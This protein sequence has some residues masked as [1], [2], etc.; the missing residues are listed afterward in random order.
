MVR[1]ATVFNI[2]CTCIVIAGIVLG[3]LF[4]WGKLLSGAES[5][6]VR[7]P[8]VDSPVIQTPAFSWPLNLSVGDRISRRENREAPSALPLEVIQPDVRSLRLEQA[9]KQADLLTFEGY[10]LAGRGALF[11]ARAEFRAALIIL[12]QALDAEKRTS[13]H[14][15][16]LAAAW[17]ALKEAEDF[18][19]QGGNGVSPLNLSEIVARH[20]SPVL[21][22]HP[23]HFLTP[24]EA[25]QI[26]LGFAQDLLSR[27]VASE[28]TGSMALRGLGKIYAEWKGA[29]SLSQG[30]SEAQAMVFYQAALNVWPENYMA[31]NDL[32]VLLAR[33]ERWE[34][35]ACVL[36]YAR[37]I[38]PNPIILANLSKVYRQTGRTYQASQILVDLPNASPPGDVTR[39]SFAQNVAWV[40]PETL[41]NDGL[42][43]ERTN[44]ESRSAQVEAK[45]VGGPAAAGAFPTGPRFPALPF[46]KS[47]T[48]M[49]SPPG[50]FPSVP[51][52]QSA[53]LSTGYLRVSQPQTQHGGLPEDMQVQGDSAN[54]V[55]LPNPA[56]PC[57]RCAVDGAIC[58]PTKWGGWNRARMIAWE[59]FA[60]GE[61]VGRAR[62]A[63]VPEYRLRVDDEL[64]IV[65]RIT[66]EE[67]SRPYRLN[68]GDQLKI[69]SATDPSLNR[70]VLIQPDGTITLLLLGQV[71]ATGLT[72]AQ[73]RDSLEQL[74]RRYYRVPAITVTPV[75]VNSKLEDLRATVDRRAGEGGQSQNVRVTPEGTIALPGLGSVKAQ[76]LTLGELQ[77]ELNERYRE[78]VEGIEAMPILV[79]RAPRYVYVLG[80][81]QTPG[82]FELTGPTTVIQAISMA[83]GWKMGANLRQ[84]VVFRRGD[85]WRLMATMLDI[86]AAL[87]GNKATPRDEIWLSD[88]DVVIV[89]KSFIQR[90]D[91]FIEM[92]FTRGIYGVLPLQTTINFSKLSTI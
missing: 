52:S 80:E 25:Y 29:G 26:Y 76:G 68:V 39:D 69:E 77:A 79:Q 9:A 44:E 42:A 34:D 27:A 50:P 6:L 91:D 11:A 35:A 37:R 5:D 83:G 89:P 51:E 15:Q 33:G 22:D 47:K 72:V 71:K 1:R 32:G 73:L 19:P 13:Q 48:P 82:R 86:Q 4:W 75:L 46:F 87:H 78:E 61:Y 40:P 28:I 43:T 64:Q 63:H 58:D 84:V 36:E 30:N 38:R 14:S 62:L 55:L 17:V 70:E 10:E 31:A 8:P 20:D 59:K 90:S 60:Q 49:A 23:L 2:R 18:L 12:A 92:V 65:Y 54:G 53:N 74:Y 24:L 7:L 45:A 85:D 67:T 41:S 81:V 57:P 66:R 16:M 21:K 88:S 56:S 3:G